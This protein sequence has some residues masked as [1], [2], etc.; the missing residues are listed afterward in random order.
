MEETM[1]LSAHK[2][3]GYGRNDEFKYPQTIWLWKKPRI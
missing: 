3:F 2:L 1:N